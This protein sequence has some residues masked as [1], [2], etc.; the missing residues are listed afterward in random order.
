[1]L[2]SSFEAISTSNLIY[3]KAH[4]FTFKSTSF[5]FNFYITLF[6]WLKQLRSLSI[7]TPFR[8][9]PT[10]QV[11]SSSPLHAPSEQAP[12]IIAPSKSIHR[13]PILSSLN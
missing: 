11:A 10:K 8:A 12:S 4:N 3:F 7:D 2:A 13:L 9:I 5:Y 1:M 6:D